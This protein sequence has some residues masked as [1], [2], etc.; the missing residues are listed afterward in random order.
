MSTIA[1]TRP[2]LDRDR[3]RLVAATSSAV[4]GVLGLATAVSA[5]AR[6]QLRT[7]LSVV[8]AFAPQTAGVS[9]VFVSF[10]LILMARGLRR[11][12]RAA[13]LITLGLLATTISVHLVHGSGPVAGIPAVLATA[14]LATQSHAFR[15]SQSRRT[16]R[17]AVLAAAGGTVASIAVAIGIAT[18]FDQT[19]TDAAAFAAATHLLGINALPLG[20]GGAFVSPALVTI[21]LCLLTWSLWSLFSPRR[22]SV[23]GDVQRGRDFD[24]AR[25]IVDQWGGD[26][27]AYFALRDDKAWFFFD[28][29]VVGYAVRG[30][31]CVVSPDPIGPPS[32]RQAAW[33]AFTTFAERQG[34]SVSVLGAGAAWLATYERSGLRPLYLG[35]EAIIDCHTFSL[36]GRAMR[37]VRQAHSRARRA[38]YTV[39]LFHSSQVDDALRRRLLELA[40]LS[41]RG[42]IERGFSMTLS[43]L[44]DPRDEG[45]MLSVAHD[46]AGVP[47]AFIQWVPCDGGWSLDVMRRNTSPELTNGVSDFLVVES[48]LAMAAR[49]ATRVGLNFAV[50]RTIVDGQSTTLSGRTARRILRATASHTQIESLLRFNTKFGPEWVPRYALLGRLDVM[51]AQSVV[52]AGAEGLSELPVIGRFMTGMSRC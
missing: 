51:A 47:Q 20:Y 1:A 10:A 4:I 41:R 31:V 35:D 42:V 45:L 37:T 24:R 6:D 29:T 40:C 32:Q 7:V 26:T 50:F 30:G 9:L 18:V 11:G 39:E 52:M 16:V 34:W 5:P 13:W 28:T 17:R 22:V 15:V 12:L 49:G 36:D 43:R 19:D 25:A 23:T 27:L 44:F 38:G 3:A 33:S 46:A 8:P 48:V 21:G 2:W 14:W